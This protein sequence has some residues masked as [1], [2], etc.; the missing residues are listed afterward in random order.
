MNYDMELD[1]YISRI[2]VQNKK[3][4]KTYEYNDS[5]FAKVEIA[6]KDLEGTLVILEYTIKVKNTGEIPGYINNIVD[7]LPSGLTFSS[8]LN[9]NWYLSGKYLYTKSLENEK[10]NPG[11]EREVKLILTKTMS[12]NNTGLINNRAEIY[13]TYNE[14]GNM[15]IDSIPNNQVDSED[16][17]GSV[18]V[19]IGIKTGG[20]IIIYIILTIINLCLIFIAIKMMIKNKIIN[21]KRER[22]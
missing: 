12:E 13:E 20:T 1:K 14:Y 16:D 19:I 6:P 7:Y 17:F 22:R 11:E 8:E 3:G 2:V 18:D 9:S 5:T 15:D 4:T 10:I 21:I